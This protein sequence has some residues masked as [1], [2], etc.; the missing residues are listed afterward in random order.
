MFNLKAMPSTPM[1]NAE[2]ARQCQMV[3]DAA[4]ADFTENDEVRQSIV[5]EV[6]GKAIALGRPF[7]DHWYYILPVEDRLYF[8]SI[9][10]FV[11]LCDIRYSQIV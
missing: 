1:T 10:E 4:R 9:H 11:V 8:T 7:D 3:S 5:S 2:I 6:V